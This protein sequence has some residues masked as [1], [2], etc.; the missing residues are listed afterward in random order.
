VRLFAGAFV[1]VGGAIVACSAEKTS[2]NPGC[3]HA[4]VGPGGIAGVVIQGPGLDLQVRD[5]F[6]RG[7]AIGTTAV[8]RRTDGALTPIDVADTL[9]IRAVYGLD[10][11]FDVTL[12][13]PFYEDAAIA[14]V[15]V[16]YTRDGCLN[17]TTI[18]VTLH[19]APGAPALRAITILG[20][21]F[22]DHPG[23]T[24]HLRPYFDANPGVST[25]VT[26]Q[27]SDTSIATIDANGV[28]TAK[29][30]KS[31][32]TAKVTVSSVVDPSVTSSLNMSVSPATS[33]P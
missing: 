22:L 1:I 29:C 30:T 23:A 28:V 3:A 13:R 12:T 32:G 19:L 6:G 20:A 14:N 31:G 21:E 7:Q 17:V 15:A 26:W 16:S 4:G 9:N 24:A 8:V 11:T 25:A 18:P 33:C 5:P 2:P 10:G 27:V